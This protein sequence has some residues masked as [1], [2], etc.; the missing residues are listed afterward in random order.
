V[1]LIDIVTVALAPAAKLPLVGDTVYQLPF[2]AVQLIDAP[3]VFWSV[4]VVLKGL[5]EPPCVPD[6]EKFVVGVTDN[7]PGVATE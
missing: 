2:D 5:K 7:D 6:D 4:Y 3:P 1:L